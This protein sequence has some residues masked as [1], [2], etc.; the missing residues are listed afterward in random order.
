MLELRN[1]DLA[2][3]F[4]QDPISPEKYQE[5]K[6]TARKAGLV[7]EL[8]YNELVP[9]IKAAKRAGDLDAAAGLLLRALDAVEAE[10]AAMGR[11]C[12]PA[13]WYYEHLA[14]VYRRL[15]EPEK[16]IAVLQRY[17]AAFDGKAEHPFPHLVERLNKAQIRAKK[18]KEKK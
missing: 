15:R 9:S 7:D 11:D 10:S 13:P 4:L 5:A 16:E 12:V 6:D 14:I 18:A 17:I 1:D 8:H 3:F 2:K